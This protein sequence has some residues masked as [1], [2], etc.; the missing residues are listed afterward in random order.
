MD[1]IWSLL[2]IKPLSESI[3]A[4]FCHNSKCHWE[5]ILIKMEAKYNVNSTRVPWFGPLCKKFVSSILRFGF[6]WSDGSP[7]DH[8]QHALKP[9]PVKVHHESAP[10]ANNPC[11][12]CMCIKH[13]N[14]SNNDRNNNNKSGEHFWM[15]IID[16]MHLIKLGIFI[17][18]FIS[19]V[20]I[21]VQNKYWPLANYNPHIDW[22]LHRNWN[23][24]DVRRQPNAIS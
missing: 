18:H 23:L 2:G 24:L 16:I 12:I 21:S 9:V 6:L 8:S 19:N 7:I 5:H 22:Y 14:N 13:E 17:R 20:F 10:C 15:R 4:Y 11:F 1:W 3:P